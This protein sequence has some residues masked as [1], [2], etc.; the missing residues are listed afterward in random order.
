MDLDRG[1]QR[2][3]L[4]VTSGWDPA[5]HGGY[6][7][8]GAPAASAATRQVPNLPVQDVPELPPGGYAAPPG[9]TSGFVRFV[10]PR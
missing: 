10:S 4:A 5:V 9:A 3:A 6:G 7:W 2:R 8:G 1:A